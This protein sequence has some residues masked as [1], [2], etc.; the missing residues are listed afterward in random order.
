MYY[1]YRLKIWRKGKFEKDRYYK[2]N[3]ES[4]FYDLR[5]Y[6]WEKYEWNKYKEKRVEEKCGKKNDWLVWLDWGKNVV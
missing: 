1:K 3:I 4:D 2:S 5:L 6:R